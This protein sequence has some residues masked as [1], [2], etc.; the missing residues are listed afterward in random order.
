MNDNHLL[1]LFK[2]TGG[3][4]RE[5]K[6]LKEFFPEFVLND[7]PYDFVEP[8]AGGAAVYWYLNN[9]NGNNIINDY[10]AEL[11][12]FYMMMRDQDDDFINPIRQSSALYEGDA[13][14]HGKQEENYYYW[15]NLDKDNGLDTLSDQER[16]ARFWIVNQLSFSGMRRFNKKG[17]FNVPY[18]HYKNLNS[19][20]ITSQDHVNLLKNTT[21]TNG[22][23]LNVL[24][25]S[26]RDNTFIFLDPPYTRVMKKYSSDNEFTEQ[27]QINLRDKLVDM[28]NA[29]WMLVI[30]QSDFIEELYDGYISEIYNLR[31]GVNIRNRFDTS[32]NHLIISNYL[33]AIS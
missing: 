11:V 3:K 21:I 25:A 30:N 15:R 5:I 28:E 31:Y 33:P 26:D 27:D 14:D 9:V 32:V 18:G 4:R 6:I 20:N 16:A 7:E 24:D 22:D 23:Y 1:P 8:F 29:S 10:D 13:T 2:W 12:N 17:E 19:T